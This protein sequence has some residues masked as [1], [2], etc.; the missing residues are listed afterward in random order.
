M[1]MR[2]ISA[3]TRNE[4]MMSEKATRQLAVVKDPVERLRLLCLQRGAAGIIGLGKVFRRMD[5]NQSG[6]LTV[7]EFTN[8]IKDSGLPLEEDEMVELFGLFDKDGSGSVNYNEFIQAIRPP[9]S[10]NRIK[11]IEL[12]FNK[13]DASGDGQVTIEDLQK[14][15]NVRSHPE[16]QNGTKTEGELL[17]TFLAKFE[18][19]GSVDGVLTKEEFIDYYSGVSASIDE[20]M[21]FDLMMRQAWKL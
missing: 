18:Q 15:Y 2:P 4:Q 20:D 7:D 6:D 17:Q 5:D 11:L 21:Y 3:Q 12:A 14:K 16:Y 10:N 8:G 19:N 13:L 9:M 1:P